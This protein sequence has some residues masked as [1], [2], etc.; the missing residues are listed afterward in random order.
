[1]TRP[2]RLTNHPIFEVDRV[3][4]EIQ[5]YQDVVGSIKRDLAA[6]TSETSGRQELRHLIKEYETELARLYLELADLRHL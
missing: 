3:R 4:H 6:G 1:M 2:D 5:F